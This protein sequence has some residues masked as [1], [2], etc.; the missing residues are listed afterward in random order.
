MK[1][2]VG[3][4]TGFQRNIR[5]MMAM[6][7]LVLLSICVICGFIKLASFVMASQIDED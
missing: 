1:A 6:F 2:A 4:N 5:K 7:A 3:A